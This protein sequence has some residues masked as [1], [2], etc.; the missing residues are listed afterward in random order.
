MEWTNLL[1]NE[2]IIS[3]NSC[4]IF[5]TY[6]DSTVFLRNKNKKYVNPTKQK[7]K[8]VMVDKYQKYCTPYD[9]SRWFDR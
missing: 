6:I 7:L 8:R 1:K 4:V 5:S 3:F 2:L 9:E